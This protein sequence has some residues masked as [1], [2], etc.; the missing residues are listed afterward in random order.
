MGIR[1]DVR[2]IPLASV[3][4]D[5]VSNGKTGTLS[6]RHKERHQLFLWFDKGA[7]KLVGLGERQGPSLLNGL[8]ALEKLKPE[9]APTVTGRHTH[10]GGFLRTLIKKGRLTRDD[11]KAALEH[12]M[13]ELLCDAFL[14]SDATFEFDEGEPDDRHFDV[15]QLDYE[16]RVAVEGQIMEAVR[17][18][19]E[20]GETRKAILSWNEILVPDPSRFPAEAEPSLRRIFAL[21]D[22]ERT[23]KDIQELTRLGQ[24][25]LMR[26]A[27]LLIRSGAARPVSAAEAFERG[28]VRAG[29]KEWEAALRMARYGL[30][31]ERKNLGLLELALKA[32]EELQQT[33]TAASFAR[34]IAS[35]HAEAGQLEAAIP[36]YQKVLAHAPKDLTAHERLFEILLQLDLKLDALA[37]GEALASAYKK[38]GLPDKALAV[39]TRLIEKVGDHSELLESVAEIQRHLG[40]RGEAVKLYS[41][42]LERAMEARDDAA[43]LD[44]CRTILKLDPRQEEAQALR[45]RL[46]TGEVEKARRR[47]RAVRLAGIAVVAV[48]AALGALVYE[49]RARD[50]WDGVRSAVNDAVSARQYRDALNLADSVIE[51]WRW[52]LK[53]RELR[54]DRADFEARHLQAEQER[55]GDLERR[56]QLAEAIQVLVEAHPLVRDPGR[57]ATL[58]ERLAALNRKRKEAEAE[59]TA[60]LAKMDPKEVGLIR[61]AMAVPALERMLAVPAPLARFAAASALGQID[62]EGAIRGLIRALADADVSVQQEAAGHLVRRGRP[63]FAASLHGPRL[64]LAAGEAAPIEWRVTNLSPGEV[65]LVLEEPPAKRLKVGGP[66]PVPAPAAEGVGRRTVRLGPGEYVGG[67]FPDLAARLPKG[68]RYPIAWAAALSWNGKPFT[69]AATGIAVD[70]R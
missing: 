69:L 23:L 56:G 2:S 40:D 22:G 16:P 31:H 27:A 62:G 48:V 14:W 6:I 25:N 28:R 60:K 30:E 37:Q 44:Y 24:F 29:K 42:L 3:L 61:D 20:W 8:L 53:S 1:G 34:Q 41:Q 39:Y 57:R 58:T 47:R 9:E 21:I 64:P 63:P 52:S 19:D 43:A 68:G 65:E 26:A 15:D 38:A 36:A 10:E 51:G 55:A 7:L 67:S 35:A 4:Q 33:E 12:Q 13:G 66:A 5:L 70:R 11:F 49:L 46:E 45:E 32:A 50:A 18:A 54:A 17:R 59:W